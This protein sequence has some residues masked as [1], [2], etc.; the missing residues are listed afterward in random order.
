MGRNLSNVC[1]MRRVLTAV[2]KVLSTLVCIRVST[3]EKNPTSVSTTGV[4][5]IVNAKLNGHHDRK[6]LFICMKFR[7]VLTIVLMVL[8]VTEV[9]YPMTVKHVGK[10]ST[11][12]PNL[13]SLGYT[14]WKQVLIIYLEGFSI[15][16]ELIYH[17]TVHFRMKV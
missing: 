8:C 12:T 7:K 13:D 5:Y 4:F 17:Q 9:R 3:L 10:S 16:A 14:Q 15:K 1:R 2:L 11:A 6:K